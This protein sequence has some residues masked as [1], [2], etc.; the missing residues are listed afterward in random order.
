MGSGVGVG[1]EQDIRNCGS[2]DCSNE[3]LPTYV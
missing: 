3:G 1:D 2:K